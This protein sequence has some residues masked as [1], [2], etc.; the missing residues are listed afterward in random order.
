[1][2]RPVAT[3]TAAIPRTGRTE[4]RAA[5][6]PPDWR[7]PAPGSAGPRFTQARRI[8]LKY[9]A[10]RQPRPSGRVLKIRRRYSEEKF[11]TACAAIGPQVRERKFVSF[12]NVG[13]LQN[14]D[15]GP[16]KAPAGLKGSSFRREY[17]RLRRAPQGERV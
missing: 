13:R 10:T 16:K 11:S 14:L 1:S 9:F 4:R 6:W 5:S 8:S 17:Q 3:A 7:G 15:A 2:S 12:S